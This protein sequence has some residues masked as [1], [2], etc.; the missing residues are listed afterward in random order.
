MALEKAR[1]KIWRSSQGP[2]VSWVLGPAVLREEVILCA[3]G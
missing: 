3:S 2:E 1:I